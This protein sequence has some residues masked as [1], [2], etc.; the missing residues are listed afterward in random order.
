ADK[1]APASPEV[2]SRDSP[3][4]GSSRGETLS[5]IAADVATITAN[6]LSRAEKAEMLA[7][8]RSEIREEVKEV[9]RDLTALE[10]RLLMCSTN[11]PL[12]LPPPDR[13]M[14]FLT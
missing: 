2:S 11:K 3:M 7:E 8:I 9:R 5:Q 14:S 4:Q 12:T 1:M 13:E 10:R 6:M